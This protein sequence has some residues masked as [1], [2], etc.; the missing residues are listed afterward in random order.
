MLDLSERLV[1]AGLAGRVHA[2]VIRHTAVER[3]HVVR[4]TDRPLPSVED[5][6]NSLAV[7]LS[8]IAWFRTITLVDDVLSSG[9]NAMGVSVALRRAGFQG[10][11]Q[12]LTA[13]HTVKADF[14]GTLAEA[15]ASEIVWLEG[16]HPRAFRD[17]R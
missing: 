3:A 1:A 6:A 2:T 13:T 15:L 9:S 8:G 4:G 10:R 5:Y 16:R 14:Q 17:N 12:V 11:V 7:D